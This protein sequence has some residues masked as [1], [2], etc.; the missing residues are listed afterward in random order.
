MLSSIYCYYIIIL[1][2]IFIL[3]EVLAGLTRQQG[4]HLSINTS[5]IFIIILSRY[6]QPQNHYHHH[7]QYRGERETHH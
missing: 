5:A 7:Q 6:P 3:D 1:R 4:A 2:V